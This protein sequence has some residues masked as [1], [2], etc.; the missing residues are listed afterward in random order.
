MTVAEAKRSNNWAQEMAALQK[1]DR[2]LSLYEFWPTAAI[3]GLVVRPLHSS[4]TWFTIAGM[5]IA[6]FGRYF[7]Q[8]LVEAMRQHIGAENDS[9]R[10]KASG[11]AKFKTSAS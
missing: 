1:R 8:S 6:K 2:E 11:A 10:A 4:P 9:V 5:Y 7:R 3:C